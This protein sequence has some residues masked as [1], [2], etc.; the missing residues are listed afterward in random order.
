M[1]HPGI[2]HGI[3]GDIE[4]SIGVLVGLCQ[5]V[6]PVPDI[7][8]VRAFLPEA[9]R[10]QGR[11]VV[12]RDVHPPH[13]AGSV[14]CLADGLQLALRVRY[15]PDQREGGNASS[16]DY[17][18]FDT[19][20]RERG[21]LKRVDTSDV[22]QSP[23]DRIDFLQ[24]I[25]RINIALL[26]LQHDLQYVSRPKHLAILLIEPNIGMRGRVEVEKIRMD[27]QTEGLIPEEQ[28]AEQ[29]EQADAEPVAEEK[30]EVL[31]RQVAAIQFC[32]Q[33]R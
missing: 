23:S 20:V 15:F 2:E 10:N 25:D 27:A 32:P 16:S 4:T 18:V 24:C 3:T 19:W 11:F 33:S 22:H 17:D 12:Q 5:F 26:H 1:L 30:I 8:E 13:A 9:G 21:H 28:G 29:D 31:L 6:D 7:L 14:N